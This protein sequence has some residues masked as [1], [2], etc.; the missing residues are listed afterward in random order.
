M[1][2]KRRHDL[3]QSVSNNLANIQSNQDFFLS[4][5]NILK[6]EGSVIDIIARPDLSGFS[7]MDYLILELESIRR[8]VV[9]G[10]IN[11]QSITFSNG[12]K[13]EGREILDILDE[14]IYFVKLARDDMNKI[15]LRI[16]KEQTF[17]RFKDRDSFEKFFWAW[18]DEI[19][20]N[21]RMVKHVK[22]MMRKTGRSLRRM[23][24]D[25]SD[26]LQMI[27]LASGAVSFPGGLFLQGVM[28]S[29]IN[30]VDPPIGMVLGIGSM[31]VC[32]S[33]CQI[34]EH[35]KDPKILSKDD[36]LI[37]SIEHIKPVKRPFTKWF[38]GRGP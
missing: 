24:Y 20:D 34:F 19:R 17:V 25:M 38:F 28:Y 8:E 14:C 33:L 10:N 18:Q 23:N 9:S 21:M 15:R 4:L 22:R 2:L 31:I 26:A 12:K 32:M 35:F 29:S 11:G 7:A 36:R 5:K 30:P 3:L 13:L 6:K 16:P 37:R 1:C 27:S